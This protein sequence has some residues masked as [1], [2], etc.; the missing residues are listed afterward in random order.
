MKLLA[1]GL[2][3]VLLG[4]F[5]NTAA[6]AY[7]YATLPTAGRG[8]GLIETQTGLILGGGAILGMLTAPV[9]GFMSE[10]FGRRRV[11]LIAMSAVGISPFVLA[12]MLGG[13]AAAL[14]VAP[15]FAILLCAR[16]VQAAFG[17]ALI[18]VSQAY[19][20]DITPDATR[21]TGMGYLGATISIGTVAGAGLVWAIG[22]FSPVL[23]FA[24]I[25]A[26]AVLS[27]VLG[28]ILLPE[29]QR[30]LV[31]EKSGA[32]VPFGAVWPYFTITALAMTANSIVQPVI[33]LRMMDQFGLEQTAAIGFAGAAVTCSGLAMMISQAIITPRLNWPPVRML[34][35]G[36]LCAALGLALLALAD[37]QALIIVSMA[38]MG[39]L[40]AFE[41]DQLEHRDIGG[42]AASRR[43]R[44]RTGRSRSRHAPPPRPCAAAAHG[45]QRRA[46]GRDQIVDQQHLVRIGQHIGMDLDRV[47]AIFER[48]VL[49]DRR[50]GQLAALADRHEADAHLDG[51][52]GAEDEAPRLDAGHMRDAEAAMRLGQP[53]DALLEPLR[54]LDQRRDVAKQDPRL[55]IVRDRTD[56]RFEIEH[57]PPLFTCEPA[58]GQ[59]G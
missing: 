53:P 39:L 7:L 47:D 16:G 36:G 19:V 40:V 2:W 26:A 29:P 50:A 55:G 24:L 4:L 54:M 34:R 12:I 58:S 59:G 6:Q 3:A 20:A 18:P 33:G 10:R 5:V 43:R 46:A 42:R 31:A 30:H 23:G 32:A 48:V 49:P 37:N 1:T 52:A 51:D 41:I 15:I 35:V 21:T 28:V 17:S 57:Q 38:I 25:A 9:W 27:F 14:P 8:I 13:S 44:G 56:Q 22:G 45:G 11:L